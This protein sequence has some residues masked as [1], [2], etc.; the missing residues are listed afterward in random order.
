MK[1]LL[2]GSI[3]IGVGVLFFSCK[4]PDNE[5]PTVKITAPKDSS[6]VSQPTLIKVD[7]QD[8]DKVEKVDFY[9]DGSIAST[10]T[11]EPWEYNWDPSGLQDSTYH[12]IMAKAYDPSDN[13]DS[14]SITLLYWT[15]HAPNTPSNPSPA[16][17]ATDVSTSVTL[18]WTGGDPDSGD[19]VTYDVYF[20]T[21]TS[22]PKE[23]SDIEET[24]YS[25][26]DVKWN[27]KYY[28][29]VVARDNH[30]DTTAGPVWN[31][32]T[33]AQPK[34]IEISYD[35]GVPDNAWYIGTQGTPDTVPDNT[36]GWC[37]R[38]TPPQ[39]P[40][41]LTKVKFW[42]SDVSHD[43]YLHVWDDDGSGGLPYTDLLHTPYR[44]N[45]NEPSIQAWWTKD[46]SNENVVISSGDFYVGFCYSYLDALGSSSTLSIGADST[47][48]FD[49]RAYIKGVQ[50]A[51]NWTILSRFTDQ[52]G[53]PIKYDL[54]IRAVGYVGGASS[55]RKKVEIIGQPA[56][57]SPPKERIEAIPVV[58]PIKRR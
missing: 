3:L 56:F 19:I 14:A 30:G 58:V 23:A 38:M 7:A 10:D 36:V 8:N 5:P 28:W 34:E 52:Y 31:F 24:S 25:P 53:N 33:P 6:I 50:G 48:P 46:V 49:D 45:A 41:T 21:E 9:I 39:Y 13:V 20:G 51:E 2:V 35:D 43:F 47:A 57:I 27:T 15:N 32:T 37:M 40:F 44:I 55:P 42:F 22:P 26:S 16:N 12:S 11:T 17:G 18:T 29:K 1:K 54:M 4:K